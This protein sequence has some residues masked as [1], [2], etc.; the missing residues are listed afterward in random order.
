MSSLEVAVDGRPLGRRAQQ[1][2]RQLLDATRAL[3]ELHGVR[4][5]RVVEI[6]RK[7]GTSPATFYQYFRDVEDAVL[8]LAAE[9][10]SELDPLTQLLEASWTGRAGID[11]ARALVDGF[12]DYWDRHRAVLRVRNLAAQEGDERF[13]DVRNRTL[14]AI[15]DRLEAKLAES[16]AAGRVA[17]ELTPYAA[18]AALVSMMERMAAYHFDLEPRGITRPDIVETV[19]RIIH[20]T[21]TGRRV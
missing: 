19:A 21:V 15:T 13:R 10:G 3:L 2:R 14:S 11:A 4:D 18:A 5:L 9:A 12:V 1:T 8:V 17:S 20:Q 7:V 16:Q 6:A